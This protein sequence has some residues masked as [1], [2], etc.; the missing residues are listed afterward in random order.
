[1]SMADV[2]AK[3]FE[4]EGEELGYPTQFR[5]GCSAAGLFVVR[6][7]SA[8]ELIA[9]SGFEI[10]E[11]AP[12][13]GILALTGVHYTDTDC[14][15]YNEIAQAFFVR[16][17]DRPSGL[18]Y[19][20]TWLDLARGEVASFTWKLQVTSRLSQYA[21]IRMWGFPKTLEEITFDRIEDHARF[22]LRID[23]QDVLSFTVRAE[24]SHTPTPLTSRV[25]SIFEGTPHV[26]YLTQSYRD[27]GVRLGHGPLALG[28]HPLAQQLRE[29][30][31][32]RRPLLSTWN[33][34]LAFSMTAPEKL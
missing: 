14:G 32:P 17:V 22:S 7:A 10:A 21:G 34:H 24:G 3:R 6:S 29:L 1:M 31:L 19:L 8:Q 30:G 25:Y 16:R 12:G 18:P 33:G 27:T 20:G 2:E 4:I 15:S 11:I 5:D 26:S 13:R 28:K 23:G 9:D